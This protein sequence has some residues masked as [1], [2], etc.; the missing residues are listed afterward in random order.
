MN[1]LIVDD[2]K[3]F[4]V[5]V[6]K[7]IDLDP[8]LTLVKEC[9][10]AMEAY[11]EI[12][13]QPIDLL[14]LD[15]EMP[16]MNGMELAKILQDK[17][18][19]II[20]ITSKFEHALEAFD[21]NV[22]DFLVKPIE[23]SRFLKAVEKAKELFKSK[24]SISNGSPQD[25]FVFIRDSSVIRKLRLDDILYLEA[26]D[27]YVRIYLPQK[28]FSIHSSLKSIEDKLPKDIFLRVHRSFII[29]LGKVDTMEGGTLFI[30]KMVV[31]VSDAYRSALNKHM[32][33]L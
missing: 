18:P 28:T 4:R 20:F 30:N 21:L 33:F 23:P 15:I 12:N 7:M 6:K 1:C 19:L 3:I 11:Q 13:A 25:R 8:S 29:N 5:I 22:V 9:T 31:P 26:K 27:N 17:R 14:F 10:N 24:K 32:E 16:G 2:Q